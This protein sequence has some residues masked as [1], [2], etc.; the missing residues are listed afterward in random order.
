MKILNILSILCVTAA[1]IIMARAVIL[2]PIMEPQPRDEI[3]IVAIYAPGES[4]GDHYILDYMVNNRVMSTYAKTMDQIDRM[5]DYW[6]QRATV[7]WLG[8]AK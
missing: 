4:Y 8:A 3:V 7:S 1:I 5:V 2:R 6:E